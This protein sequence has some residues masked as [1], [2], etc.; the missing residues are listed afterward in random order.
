M[1]KRSWRVLFQVQIYLNHTLL[2]AIVGCRS[3]CRTV[4]LQV[5]RKRMERP[6]DTAAAL[7]SVLEARKVVSHSSVDFV[8]LISIR[9]VGFSAQSLPALFVLWRDLS[10]FWSAREKLDVLTRQDRNRSLTSLQTAWGKRNFSEM[11]RLAYR[12]SGRLGTSRG[13]RLGLS[14]CQDYVEMLQRAR[15][16]HVTKA[17]PSWEV[18]LEFRR[19]LVW[20]YWRCRCKCMESL[21][22]GIET[23]CDQFFCS[24]Y[25]HTVC[26]GSLL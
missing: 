2:E 8:A 24:V 4:F 18:R 26:S 21:I 19:T 14:G 6:D 23:F 1:F 3:A 25:V 11:W 12:L 13:R 5:T 7:Q 22:H 20:A 9:R 17:V 15:Y 10:A 16:F